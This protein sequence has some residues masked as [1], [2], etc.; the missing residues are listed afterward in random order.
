M[1]SWGQAQKLRFGGVHR[2]GSPI[3]IVDEITRKC[4]N[5]LM[6]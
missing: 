2:Q 1:G 4:D 6:S 5:G 3:I